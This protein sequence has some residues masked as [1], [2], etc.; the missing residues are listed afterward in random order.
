MCSVDL[1][2]RVET[3]AYMCTRVCTTPRP[4]IYNGNIHAYPTHIRGIVTI[5]IRANT[6]TYIPN[7]HSGVV[8]IVAWA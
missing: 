2:S 8:T 7:T 5:V 1:R 3:H 4:N 6:H